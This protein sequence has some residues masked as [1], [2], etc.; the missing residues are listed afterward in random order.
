MLLDALDRLTRDDREDGV[1]CNVRCC[2]AYDDAADTNVL[3]FRAKAAL[4]GL[5]IRVE[6]DGSRLST[7]ARTESQSTVEHPS[8]FRHS[9]PAQTQP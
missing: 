2:A 4:G 1:W 8:K 3:L 9:R 7:N 5:S 6:F